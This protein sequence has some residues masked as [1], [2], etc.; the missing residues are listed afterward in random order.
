MRGSSATLR[1]HGLV[2]VRY[3]EG[4]F[5][6][7]RADIFLYPDVMGT[8]NDRDNVLCNLFAI[9]DQFDSGFNYQIFLFRANRT[10]DKL[11]QI[12]EDSE[13]IGKK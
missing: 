6:V 11:T 9:A 8:D 2:S 13:Y 12:C 3:C 10:C 1:L 7:D 5:L 4:C